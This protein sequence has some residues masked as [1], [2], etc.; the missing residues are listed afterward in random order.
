MLLFLIVMLYYSLRDSVQ[1]TVYI[2][3]M[4]MNAIWFANI[5]YLHIYIRIR[6]YIY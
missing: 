1:I 5:H 2:M 4:S 3:Y 6:I